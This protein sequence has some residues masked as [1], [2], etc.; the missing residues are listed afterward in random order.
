VH[1]R[2]SVRALEELVAS[3]AD[4]LPAQR[5]RR[6]KPPYLMD[7]EGQVSQA[8]GTRVSI[9]PGRAKNTGKLV[10]EYYNLDDF[11]RLLVCLGAKVES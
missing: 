4:G 11:D 6:S 10:I 2:L 8:V 9:Q 1:Q 5:K 3:G 7:L